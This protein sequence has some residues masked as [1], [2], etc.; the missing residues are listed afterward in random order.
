VTESVHYSKAPITEATIDLRVK[1]A[2]N[3]SI[4]DLAVVQEMVADRY[5]TREGEYFYSGRVYIEE[6]GEALQTDASHR[7]NGFRLT[8]RDKRQVFFARLDGFALSIRAPYDS[9]E[10]FR[11]EARDLWNIYRS[12]A[13]PEGVTRAAVRY[14]NQ[15]D[16]P[17]YAPDPSNVSLED[18]LNV[19]PEFPQ[20]WL[21]SN[22]FM[23]LQIWQED[24]ECWLIVNEAPIM[25]SGQEAGSLQLDLDFFRERFEEPWQA[26]EDAEVW[27]FLEQ[28]HIRKNEVFEASITEETR[29][30]IR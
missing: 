19:Y 27:A 14:I 26:D 24:P 16:I 4:D 10:P 23:Q 12:V 29:R 30:F 13:K 25:P 20:R 17:S 9:W 6:A 3:T 15:L 2:P 7:H 8:S 11:D 5:P 21:A 1:Q 22:F 18:Y 28:L